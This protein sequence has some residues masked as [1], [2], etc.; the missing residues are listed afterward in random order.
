MSIVINRTGIHNDRKW[1]CG[2]ALAFALVMS[3]ACWI[4]LAMIWAAVVHF[5]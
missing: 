2:K 3:A 1:P 5:T 4:A